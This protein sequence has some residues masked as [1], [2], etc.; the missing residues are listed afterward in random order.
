VDDVTFSKINLT[1]VNEW[2]ATHFSLATIMF[3][4]FY[5]VGS[6]LAFRKQ[7]Y[8]IIEHLVLN[9][10]L[11]SQRLLLRLATFPLLVIFN[12]SPHL[13]TITRLYILCDII[14]M[15]WSYCQFFNKI[16]RMRSF[17]LSL[18]SYAI[19]FIIYFAFVVLAFIVAAKIL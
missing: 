16:S 11:G 1:S 8:N 7:G 2:M 15:T 3:L 17:F 4:P 13:Q 18:L 14:L 6:F 5:T 10:F 9:A 19:F 12:G